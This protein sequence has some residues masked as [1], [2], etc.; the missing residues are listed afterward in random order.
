[1]ELTKIR[2]IDSIFV[3]LRIYMQ[4]KRLNDIW[5]IFSMYSN[6]QS[7]V[8][9][10]VLEDALVQARLYPDNQDLDLIMVDYILPKTQNLDFH[11]FNA[12]FKKYCS[13]EHF[14]KDL[15]NRDQTISSTLTPPSSSLTPGMPY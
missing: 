14:A 2:L 8:S 1:M 13:S 11:A 15:M 3:E 4:E 7:N 9:K 5:E 12:D 6:N 10:K